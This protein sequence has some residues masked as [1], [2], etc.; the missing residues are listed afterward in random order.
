MVMTEKPQDVKPSREKK[1]RKN[2]LQ[3]N[4]VKSLPPVIEER[5]RT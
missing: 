3:E 2:Q 5:P 1:K 4:K